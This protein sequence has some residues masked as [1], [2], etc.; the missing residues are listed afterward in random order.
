MKWISGSPATSLAKRVQRSHRMQ[1]SRSRKHQVADRDR[2]LVVALLLDE[3]ALAGAVA[4]RLVLQRALAALVAHRAVER[5]VGEQELEHALL[6]PLDRGRLGLDLHAR[7]TGAMHDTASSGPRGRRRPRRGTC[8]TCRPASSAGGSR[9][10]G[11]RR[12]RRSAA[13]MTSWPFAGRRAACR[14]RDLDGVR[15]RAAVRRPPRRWSRCR[16]CQCPAATGII[17]RCLIFASN[18]SRNSVARVD[19]RERDGPTKQI[20]R[21]SCMGTRRMALRAELG[22][23]GVP[24]KLPGQIV[25]AHL[26]QQVEV[27]RAAVAVADAGQDALEPGACLRGTACTC[28]SS[29]R[30][31]TG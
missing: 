2:L 16:S 3:P 28:R 6:H 19:G 10:A 12:R 15:L 23:R 8:G 20:H 25:V 24:G 26:E 27:G 4:D 31:R 9:S 11:C 7:R 29:R 30:R 22:R 17:V 1:R 13:S 5:V 21:R 18:S 14:R